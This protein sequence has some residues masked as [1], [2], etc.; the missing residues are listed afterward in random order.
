MNKINFSFLAVISLSIS[1]AAQKG[2]DTQ[3]R[4]IHEESVKGTQITSNNGNTYDFGKDKTK[5]RSLLE[6]PYKLNSR[7]DRL[8]ERVIDALKEKKISVDENSSRLGDGFI[9]TEPFIFSK[10]VVITQSELNHYAIVPDSNTIY[11]RARYILTIE[12]QSIDGIQNTVAVTAKIEGKSENGIRSEWT[13]LQSNG[14]AED[15]FLVKLVE[16]VTGNVINQPI[17]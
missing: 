8:I 5:T 13:S 17:K 16:M 6:N 14:I 11:S 2:V 7:R 3:S 1:I 10:G 4:K 15:E 9:V 12:V